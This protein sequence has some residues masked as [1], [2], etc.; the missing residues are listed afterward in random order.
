MGRGEREEVVE[1]GVESSEEGLLQLHS[2]PLGRVEPSASDAGLLWRWP[3]LSLLLKVEVVDDLLEPG[4]Q[5]RSA[6]LEK[7]MWREKKKTWRC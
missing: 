5:A 7:Q 6:V 4:N 1:W 3:W 2:R